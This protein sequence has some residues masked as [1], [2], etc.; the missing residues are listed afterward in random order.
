MKEGFPAVE[1]RGAGRDAALYGASAIHALVL[2]WLPV[3]SIY[4]AW[5][6]I[7]VWP[8]AAGAALAALVWLVRPRSAAFAGKFR[9]ALAMGV[10]AGATLAPVGHQVALRADA[11]PS[12]HA[13][14]HTIIVEESAKALLDGENPYSFDYSRGPLSS[15]ERGVRT[16]FPYMPGMIAFGLSR[17]FLGNG[18]AGDARIIFVLAGLSIFAV[19]ALRWKTSRDR[20]LLALQVLVILPTGSVLLAGGGHEFPVL[21]LMLLSLVLLDGE[22]YRGSG[23]ALGAAMAIKQTAWVLFPFW[24][25]VIVRRGGLSMTRRTVLPIAAIASAVILPLLFWYPRA[26]IEDAVKFPLDIGT[27]Q[28]IARGP[29]LGRFLLGIFPSTRPWLSF[30]LLGIAGAIS[31]IILFRKPPAGASGAAGYSGLI[32]ALA[33]ALSTAGRAGYAIYPINLLLWSRLLKPGPLSP[34]APSPASRSSIL[35]KAKSRR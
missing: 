33:I 28:T 5:G 17:G 29:T 3:H 26:F 15:W 20:W 9:I 16:H 23:V 30:A 7:A 24:L 25:A 18:P 11:G 4:R 14:S 27:D 35:S 13:Q 21:A 19:A 2:S 12:K 1:R 32:F 31:A 22:R 8:Y 10:L 6:R 34:S